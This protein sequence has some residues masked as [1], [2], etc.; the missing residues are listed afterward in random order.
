MFKPKSAI[1]AIIL[2]SYRQEIKIG[3]NL[4]SRKDSNY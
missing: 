3:I 1:N 4:L 2:P